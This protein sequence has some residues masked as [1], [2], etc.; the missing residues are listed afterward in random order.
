[1]VSG[2]SPT[3]ARPLAERFPERLARCVT[4][5][6]F[7]GIGIAFFIVSDIGVPPWDVFHQGVSSRSGLAVGTVIVITGFAVLLLWIPLRLRPGIGTV[8][9]ALQIGIVEN[10]AEPLIPETSSITGRALYVG[11]GMLA[12]AAG[13]GL[14]IGAELGPGPRD[15]LMVGLSVRCGISVR[16]ARTVVELAVLA[17]GVALGG[18]VG[19]GTVVFALGIGPLVQITLRLFEMSSATATERGA[20]DQ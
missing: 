8:L 13:S 17:V 20:V 16:L 6:A 11:L 10:L 1:M 4:G 3:A 12:I 14:Y 2:S 15:G 9:N 19:F 5:L 7:F 18:T